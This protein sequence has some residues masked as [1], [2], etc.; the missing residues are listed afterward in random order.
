MEYDKLKLIENKAESLLS[1]LKKGED[2]SLYFNALLVLVVL[3][4]LS[5]AASFTIT[6]EYRNLL[7]YL[8]ILI[9]LLV[10]Y[11]IRMSSAY[12]ESALLKKYTSLRN[13]DDRLGYVSGLLKYLSSGINVKLRRLKTVRLIY[14]IIFPI[15]LVILKELLLG[16]GNIV[17]D[18]L[19]AIIIGSTFWMIYFKDDIEELSYGKQDVEEMIKKMAL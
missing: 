19:G 10:I 13:S 11:N 15:F 1:D 7:F 2:S 3:F 5:L 8:A 16:K 4:F 18:L 12:K 14:A 9:G 6:G 17:Y